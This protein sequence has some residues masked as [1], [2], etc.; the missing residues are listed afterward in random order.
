MDAAWLE[1]HTGMR[2]INAVS[3]FGTHLPVLLQCAIRSAPLNILELG[4]GEYSTPLLHAFACGGRRV[5]TVD[6][7]VA[8]HF[9]LAKKYA[10]PSHQFLLVDH[11][12]EE[13]AAAMSLTM[14]EVGPLS[15][16]GVVLIDHADF[17]QRER[18]ARTLLPM[19]E[20]LVWHDMHDDPRPDFR[21]PWLDEMVEQGQLR[22]RYFSRWSTMVLSM[23]RDLGDLE[24]L[25]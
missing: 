11:N 14:A 12:Y 24:E 5:V 21:H 17:P 2:W 6:D 20:Y 3:N 8:L 18:D 25:D 10:S 16:L 13:L 23:Y 15:R 7:H 1:E 4:A 22:R 9:K 19:T